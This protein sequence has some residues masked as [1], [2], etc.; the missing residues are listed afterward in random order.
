MILFENKA[1]AGIIVNEVM[2]EYGEILTQCYWH[3]L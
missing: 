3:F 1:I 2:L